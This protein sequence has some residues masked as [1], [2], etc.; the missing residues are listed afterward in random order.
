MGSLLETIPLIGGNELMKG[1]YFWI[2]GQDL[3]NSTIKIQ[4]QGNKTYDIPQA[5]I[6]LLT[7][8]IK[9]MMKSETFKPVVD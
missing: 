7:A 3:S 4:V 5:K 2:I 6:S 1:S 8:S 9:S